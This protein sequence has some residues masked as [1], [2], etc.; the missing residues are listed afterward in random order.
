MK[1]QSVIGILMLTLLLPLFLSFSNVE[2]HAEEE[3]N[4]E[5]T[6][7]YGFE[8]YFKLGKHMPVVV[9]VTNNGLDF[10]G[11]MEIEIPRSSYEEY[12]IYSQTVNLPQNSEKK[13][14]FS[15]P[16]MSDINELKVVLKENKKVVAQQSIKVNRGRLTGDQLLIGV[17]S[18]DFN[19]VS[20]FYN[21]LYSRGNYAFTSQS[22][23]LIKIEEDTLPD[24]ARTLESLDAVIINNFNTSS[25]SQNQYDAIKGWVEQGGHLIIGTGP[26][27]SKTLSVFKDD[28]LGGTIGDSK[29]IETNLG[30]ETVDPITLEIQ[31]IHIQEGTELFEDGLIKKVQKGLGYVAVATFDLGLEPLSGWDGNQIFAVTLMRD[32]ITQDYLQTLQMQQNGY[33]PWRLSNVLSVIPNVKM[34]NFNALLFIMLA[35]I[36]FVGPINYF[37]LKKIDKRQLMWLTVP[38]MS[39][40]FATIIF[41][42]TSETRFKKPFINKANIIT[43]NAGGVSS[44]ESY[45]GILSPDSRNLKV[46]L[47]REYAASLLNDENYYYHGVYYD[48][49]TNRKLHSIIREEGNQTS[50]EFMNVTAFKPNYFKIN[51]TVNLEGSLNA[52]IYLN[53]NLIEGTI[54]NELGIDLEDAFIL[55]DNMYVNVGELKQGDKQE[56]SSK[57]TSVYNSYELSDYLFPYNY[58]PTYGNNSAQIEKEINFRQRRG[59]IELK[60][61]NNGYG[62]LPTKEFYLV[63]FSK[64]DDEASLFDDRFDEYN[65]NLVLIPIQLNYDKDGVV[66]LPSGFFKPEMLNVSQ[67]GGYDAMYN[68][69]YGE[70]VELIFSIDPKITAEII[71]FD[72]GAANSRYGGRSFKGE[73][74]LYNYKNYEYEVIDYRADLDEDDLKRYLNED[75]QLRVQY[76][77]DSAY[78]DAMTI[79]LISVQGKVE[80]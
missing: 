26:T 60:F 17:I 6:I 15:I 80:K 18:D 59:M 74:R 39:I 5:M 72:R 40:V 57:I 71:K 49:N 42:F 50:F 32:M 23:T 43:F 16:V 51:S 48:S 65:T 73:I 4:I 21:G 67:N 10:E 41:T 2:V 63:G 61:S 19:S 7:T 36:I 76:V 30:I 54:S 11:D 56:I 68:I 24:N 3:Q 14:M 20:Y 53:G 13:V 9:E 79:P 75:N 64:F 77:V 66:N 35:Y 46:D 38:I 47:P 8:R 52:D 33:D 62:I 1:K 78:R 44:M 70:S 37:I 12:S 69:L 27:Y 29:Q 25:F 45:A 22:I 31:N 28:F 58:A 55:G 34:P